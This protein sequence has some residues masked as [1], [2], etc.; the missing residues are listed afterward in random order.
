MDPQ[1]WKRLEE[2]FHQAEEKP[3]DQ[4]EAFLQ[5]ACGAD[6]SLF[7]QVRGLLQE[8]TGNGQ[9]LSSHAEQVVVEMARS[10][11]SAHPNLENYRLLRTLGEGGMGVVYEAEQ[12]S[13]R[14]LVALKVVRSVRGASERLK[15]LFQREAEALARLQH[16]GIATIFESGVSQDGQP[17]LAM[18]LLQGESLSDWMEKNPPPSAYDRPALLRRLN[19]FFSIADAIS[20]AHQNGV[21]HRDIK[22]ANIFVLPDSS[23]QS[24][25]SG[26]ASGRSQMTKILDFGLARI[27]AEKTAGATMTE[28]GTVQGSVPYMSPEQ[29]KGAATAI[30]VRTDVYALGVLLYELLT[31]KHPYLEP[32]ATFL[33][34]IGKI[35]DA[36]VRSFLSLGRK[37]LDVDLETIVAKAMEKE[38]VRRYQSVAGLVQDI[39][40]Y[41]NDQ[42]ILARPPS[43]LYT[44][45]KLVRRNRWP[46]AAVV[47]V[48]LSVVGFTIQIYRKNIAIQTEAESARQVSEFMLS[49]FENADSTN[50]GQ[51]LEVADLLRVGR[52]RLDKESRL[53]PEVRA[54]MLD[55]IGMAFCN[56]VKYQEA[57]ET[58]QA[59][60]TLREKL[61]GPDSRESM[62]TWS[63]IQTVYFDQGDT[64]KAIAAAQKIL[65]L[66]V[67]HYGEISQEAMG[68][69]EKLSTSYNLANEPKKAEIHLRK[70]LEI[71][72][73][74]AVKDPQ[75]ES[76]LLFS[77]ARLLRQQ[78]RFTE[79]VEPA[80]KGMK[81]AL[82]HGN[83]HDKAGGYNMLGTTYNLANQLDKAAENLAKSLPLAEKVFGAAH[84]NTAIVRANYGSALHR[85]KRYPEAISELEKALQQG[86]QALGPNHPRIAE[87]RH[88]L[89]EP[90]EG[91]G[92]ID[93][94][95]AEL[96]ASR[97]ISAKANGE[98]HPMTA[99]GDMRLGA[100]YV[101]LGK[102]KE[103]IIRLDRAHAIFRST[104]SNQADLE[105]SA[106][107][108]ETA[109]AQL[110]SGKRTS[111]AVANIN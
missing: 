66:A 55:K 45:S 74:L 82:E 62:D 8:V 100:L 16:P 87:L 47:I 20:Y 102:T 26:T 110:A 60:L 68:A 81:L 5:E 49:L 105:Q 37:D 95:E 41:L 104:G 23:G 57:Y 21:I 94:A 64:A 65:D 72:P 80:E 77:L 31:G 83:D 28:A 70:A 56:I 50:L 51:R 14:R 88:Q 58:F 11:I 99:R 59:S 17:F 1:R 85:L 33:E 10:A 29:A 78:S 107:L 9:T 32:G 44:I 46:V 71:Y 91:A 25:A 69:N 35:L 61:Y 89:A 12:Q 54:R 109:R 40:R 7:M 6:Q 36:P 108:L 53:Q 75:I 67:R 2:L 86:V 43:A 98:K 38:P 4:R 111:E 48:L 97:E 34:A 96:L 93:R 92:A 39:D 79:A 30:D 101:R 18:E 22:P 24:S 13:P 106:K 15:R 84:P 103:A 42:P 52:K 90:L 73:G 19:L 3:L 27:T 63:G 76:E